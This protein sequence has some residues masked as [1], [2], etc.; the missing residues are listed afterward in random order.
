MPTIEIDFINFAIT[1]TKSHDL[2]RLDLYTLS[3]APSTSFFAAIEINY[4][5]SGKGWLSN[6]AA[7]NF[8]FF[9][10]HGHQYTFGEV[11]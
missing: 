7:Q 2:S 6:R 4:D 9:S 10:K 11:A 5:L 8:T 3:S 1:I